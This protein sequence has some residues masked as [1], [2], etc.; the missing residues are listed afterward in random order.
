MGGFGVVLQ[1]IDAAFS[2]CTAGTGV[3]SVSAVAGLAVWV[4]RSRVCDCI[5]AGM[6]PDQRTGEGYFDSDG[7]GS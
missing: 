4:N 3:W 5:R 7:A 1:I 2:V 6:V